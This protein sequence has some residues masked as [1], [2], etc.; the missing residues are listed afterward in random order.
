MSD[1]TKEERMIELASKLGLMT[2]KD[3]CKQVKRNGKEI[4]Y[5][6]GK[7]YIK[8]LR[9]RGVLSTVDVETGLQKIY[10][11]QTYLL[12]VSFKNAVAAANDDTGTTPPEKAAYLME[13][14]RR[15]ARVVVDLMKMSGRIF[16]EADTIKVGKEG[17]TL[18]VEFC[19][20]GMEALEQMEK[21][22]E[23]NE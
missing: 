22:P 10:N 9:D 8:E 18:K 2:L 14:F 15:Q 20:T 16:P 21:P 3:A 7:R 4:S 19:N 11:Q 6:T 17:A 5:A 23:P 12:Q 13:N 1:G